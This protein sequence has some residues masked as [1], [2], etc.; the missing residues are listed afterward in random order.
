MNVIQL[1]ARRPARVP[2]FI[3]YSRAA[4]HTADPRADLADLA[5]AAAE[6]ECP[7]ALDVETLPEV[8]PAGFDGDILAQSTNAGDRDIAKRLTER[9]WPTQCSPDLWAAFNDRTQVRGIDFTAVL[10]FIGGGI[11]AG[12]LLGW[13]IT[14]AF[15]AYNAAILGG[16]F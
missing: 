16:S 5:R 3:S 1:H 15:T 4:N 14:D 8:E 2:P 7:I 10:F 11:I 12:S 9:H 13:A 6:W